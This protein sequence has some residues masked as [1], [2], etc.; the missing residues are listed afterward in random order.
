MIYR[1]HFGLTQAPFAL[2]PRTDMVFPACSLTNALQSL[3]RL[4]TDG[5]GIVKVTG[6]VGT[7]KTLLCRLLLERLGDQTALAYVAVPPNCDS[8]QLLSML[9]TEFDITTG[10]A[11]PLA[12][13]QSYLLALHADDK[14]AILVIDE[15]QTLDAAGLETIRLLSN[16]ESGERSLLQI[17][18]FAQPELD[19]MLEADNLRQLQQR[20]AYALQTQPLSLAECRGYLQHRV[21][22]VRKT[23][24]QPLFSQPALLVLA[25][26]S[27][28][29]P[30][31]LNILAD[32]ALLAA[33]AADTQTVTLR[34]ALTAIGECSHPLQALAARL[35]H[36]L[37][38]GGAIVAAVMLYAV[39]GENA[40]LSW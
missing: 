9:A 16:L 23:G 31:V 18:M 29:V 33:Y 39:A 4:L 15:A 34:H 10:A 8:R 7:G 5:H 3:E 40:G 12:L 32:R 13:L 37:P 17:V 1:E 20:I 22:C 14:K 28:G 25:L 35:R 36:N 21:A 26:A 27:L 24:A 2:T 11:S 19:G 6:E 30:R 38:L